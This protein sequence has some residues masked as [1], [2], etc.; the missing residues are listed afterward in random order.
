M[1]RLRREMWRK[2]VELCWCTNLLG[3]YHLDT[4]SLFSV[5][6]PVL[7][8]VAQSDG[9]KQRLS[10]A[11]LLE[12]LDCET[13]RCWFLVKCIFLT[14]FHILNWSFFDRQSNIGVVLYFLYTDLL[15][16]T[17]I[18]PSPTSTLL[19]HTRSLFLLLHLRSSD[20]VSTPVYLRT[21]FSSSP[22]LPGVQR[23]E[24]THYRGIW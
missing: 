9:Q 22:H 15:T 7:V 24:S 12:L 11:T 17:R 2:R 5:E 16:R 20:Q 14:T 13:R 19:D 8:W 3:I 6:V 1:A 23:S 21:W 4:K 10:I 18:W